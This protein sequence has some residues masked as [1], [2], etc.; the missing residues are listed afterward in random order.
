MTHRKGFIVIIKKNGKPLREVKSSSNPYSNVFLPF[1]S[2]YEIELRNDNFARA[3]ARVSIDGTDVLG[4]DEIIVPAYGSVTLERFMVDGDLNKGNKFKF[5]P[6]S[7]GD[8][9]NPDSPEN[10][11]VEVELWS[12]NQ[13]VLR[14]QLRSKMSAPIRDTAKPYNPWQSEYLC[15][16]SSTTTWTDT[17]GGIQSMN[18]ASM[19]MSDLNA[20]SGQTVD[21]AG[22]TV[23]GDVSHQSFHRVHFEGKQYPSTVIKLQLK[24]L[25]K[26]ITTKDRL[27]CASCGRRVR[28][29]FKY[30]PRCG[31]PVTIA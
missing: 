6:V 8:V 12:E 27:Y 24:G 3:T 10:G 9:Q 25:D 26:E 17:T 7:D 30:C 2:E 28:Y 11:L 20:F 31:K 13:E 19:D 29:N 18:F 14:R 22:A 1:Y 23:E 21:Q 16:D 4:T 15:R 5:V